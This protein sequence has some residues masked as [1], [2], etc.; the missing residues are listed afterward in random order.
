MTSR[1]EDKRLT[2][3]DSLIESNTPI[4]KPQWLQFCT[5]M[6][7]TTPLRSVHLVLQPATALEARSYWV[8]DPSGDGDADIGDVSFYRAA[9]HA[10]LLHPDATVVLD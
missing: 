6:V 8:H 2:E 5:Q 10:Q 4:T 9:M 3:W 7:P 1:T